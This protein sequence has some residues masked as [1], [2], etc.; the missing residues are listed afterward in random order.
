MV[1]IFKEV[2]PEEEISSVPCAQMLRMYLI[3]GTLKVTVYFMLNSAL[4]IAEG[5]ASSA[6]GKVTLKCKTTNTSDAITASLSLRKVEYIF[7]YPEGMANEFIF[8]CA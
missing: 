1:V 7:P 3:D 8:K 4:Q 6:M 2:S 5:T